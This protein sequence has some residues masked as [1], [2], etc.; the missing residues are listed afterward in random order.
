MGE[1]NTSNTSYD[2][3]FLVDAGIGNVI[4]ALYAVE[5]CLREEKK[6]GLYIPNI[7]ASFRQFLKE[8]YGLGVVLDDINGVTTQ[9]LIHSFLYQENDFPEYTYYYYIAADNSHS[10]GQRSETE[11]YLDVVR[12]ILNKNETVP[13]KLQWLDEDCSTRISELNPSDKFIL[14]PGGSSHVPAR[15]WPHFKLLME[16]LGPLNTIIVGGKDD[17]NFRQSYCYP[18]LLSWLPQTVLRRK[19]FFNICRTLGLLKKHSHWKGVELNDNAFFEIFSWAELV[20]LFSRCKAFI[21][22]DGGL[23]H[24]AAASGAR[25]AVMFGPTSE[26]KNKPLS[27]RITAINENLACSPC[28]FGVAGIFLAQ[29]MISCPYQVKCLGQ[30]SV[31]TVK[32]KLDIE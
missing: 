7:N 27:S 20:A 21:G 16:S 28:Q 9:Y 25:G 32:N 18:S 13:D 15:R 23:S 26:K 24:L 22:N 4:Q 1:Q 17:L 31:N 5:L 12:G 14:Y 8:S 2:F 29:E 19:G 6:T 30:I 11:Q 10:V 3:I